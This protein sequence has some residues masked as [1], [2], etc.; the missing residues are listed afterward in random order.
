MKKQFLLLAMPLMGGWLMAQN[1]A[2]PAAVDHAFS[3]QFPNLKAERW[4]E[5]DGIWEA[6]LHHQ[7][8]EIEAQFTQDGQWI[9]TE[10]ELHIQNLPP[11]VVNALNA[12]YP[13]HQIQ[14]AEWQESAKEGVRYELEIEQ[15][16]KTVEILLDDKGTILAEEIE[17]NDD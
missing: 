16:G 6:Q 14:E 4:V 10:M 3:H 17:D 13:N 15:N 5:E 8:R 7:G 12:K 2:V 1:S 11:V 9:E